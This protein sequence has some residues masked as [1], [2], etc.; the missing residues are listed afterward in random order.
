VLQAERL[1][2]AEQGKGF[3]KIFDAGGLEIGSECPGF[4]VS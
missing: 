4:R 3:I 2:G 1:V